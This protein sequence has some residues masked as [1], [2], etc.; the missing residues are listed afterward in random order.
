MSRNDLPRRKPAPGPRNAFL[1]PRFD[2]YPYLVSRIGRS[3]LRHIV[4][5]PADWP[6]DRIVATARAMAEAN[7]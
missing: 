2:G 1:P 5:V 7:R 6:R 3:A 4:L